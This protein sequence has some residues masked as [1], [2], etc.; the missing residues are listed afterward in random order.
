MVNRMANK[1]HT[2]IPAAGIAAG[3][4]VAAAAAGATYYFYAAKGAKRHRQAAAKWVAGMKREVVRDAK[5]AGKLTAPVI[6]GIVDRV[7]SGYEAAKKADPA[8]LGRA[9]AELKKNWR[10]VAQE[11]ADAG[12]DARKGAKRAASSAKRAVQ[13]A[14][15]AQSAKR[16][17]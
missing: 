2:G 10:M 15:R 13:G 8:E 17:N 14:G 16:A 11:L 12:T 6:A 3:A 5:K 9:A 1:K 4:A 7:A